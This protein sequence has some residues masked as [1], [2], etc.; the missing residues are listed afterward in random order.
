M[1]CVTSGNCV[2]IGG[3]HGGKMDF[4]KGIQ[5][6]SE[7]LQAQHCQWVQGKVFPFVVLYGTRSWTWWPLWVPSNS[8]FHGSV[9]PAHLMSLFR[10]N[11][12]KEKNKQTHKKTYWARVHKTSAEGR[13]I[14]QA[15]CLYNKWLS[16]VLSWIFLNWKKQLKKPNNL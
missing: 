8:W 15:Q 7:E 3:L 14:S 16:C 11:H 12:C 10:S 1:Q 2:S 6:W 5:R 4:N 9:R 13:Y